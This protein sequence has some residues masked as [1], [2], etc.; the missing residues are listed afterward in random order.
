MKRNTFL[1]IFILIGMSLTPVIAQIA[2]PNSVTVN[3]ET[4]S[5][6]G[7]V[8]TKFASVGSDVEIMAHTRGHTSNT[9]VTADILRYDMDP[10][11]IING[12]LPLNGVIV[13][14]V[15]LQNTGYHIDDV[16]TMTW[17]GVYTVPVTSLGGTYAASIKAEHGN[18]IAVDDATQITELLLNKFET[19]VLQPLDNAWDTA[20]PLGEIKNEFA[21]LETAGTSN[22]GWANFVETATEGTGPG[23]SAQLWNNMLDAGR[24]QYDMEAGA[25]FLEALMEFLDS[26]DVDAGLDMVAAFLLYGDEFPLPRVI[27]DFGDVID[28]MQAFDPIE[29]FTR[30]EGTGDFE[31]AY[32]ALLGSNEWNDLQESIE[33]LANNQLP[34]QSI[35]NI[36]HNIALLAVS[37]HPEAIVDSLEAWAQ[38]LVDGDWESMTP[39]QKLIVRMAEMPEPIIEDYNGDDIPDDEGEITWQYELLLDTSEGQAWS[40]KMESSSS[41]VND[42]FDE[43]NSMPEHI[44]GHVFDSLTNPV[45]ESFG[46]SAEEFGEWIEDSSRSWHEESWYDWNS[47]DETIIFGECEYDEEEGE[48][49][50]SS[51]KMREVVTSIHDR[52]VLDIGITMEFYPSDW[53]QWEPYRDDVPDQFS[54]AM[55]NDKTPAD[56]ESTFL[57]RD[58]NEYRYYGRLTAST[59]EDTKWSFTQALSNFEPPCNDCEVSEA[60][61]EF[62]KLNPS[63]LESMAWENNDEMFIVS[64]V[65]VLVT[66]DETTN[67][68]DDYNIKATAYSHSG[69]IENAEVDLA[70]LR[71]SPQAAVGA[72]EA[73]EVEGEIEYEWAS[74]NSISGHYNADDLENGDLTVEINPRGHRD[75]EDVYLYDQLTFQDTFQEDGNGNSEWYVDISSANGDIGIAEVTTTGKTNSGIEFEFTEQIPMPGTPD[76]MYTEGY[77]LDGNNNIEL[78]LKTQSWEG[79]QYFD[80][81]NFENININWGDGTTETLELGSWESDSYDNYLYHQYTNDPG[82]ENQITVDYKDFDDNHYYHY[83]TYK[84]DDGFEKTYYDEETGED[85]TYYEYNDQ[86]FEWGM[87]NYCSLNSWESMTPSPVIIDSFITDGPFEVMKEE[88]MTSDSNGEAVMTVSPTLPG[89]YVSIAQVKVTR[90]DGSEM[91]GVGMN[92][93]A[94]TEGSISIGGDL[95]QETTFGGI[96]VYSSER[97]DLSTGISIA[98]TDIPCE[99]GH[100]ILVGLV[101]LVLREAFPGVDEDAWTGPQ[102]DEDGG[103]GSFETE[104]E[105]ECGETAKN[106]EVDLESPM[107]LLAAI[108]VDSTGNNGNN[109]EC[110]DV[111]EGEYFDD[112]GWFYPYDNNE[113]HWVEWDDYVWEDGSFCPGESVGTGDLILFPNAL[114]IG[115]VL[116][117]PASLKLTGELGPGQV[118]NIALSDEDGPASRILAVATPKEGFDPATIDLSA[119]TEFLYGEGVREEIGWVANDKSIEDVY[120][121]SDAWCEDREDYDWET[122]TQY[123]KSNVRMR[124]YVDNNPW[125]SSMPDPKDTVLKDSSGFLITPVRDWYQ[126]WGSE[127]YANYEIDLS[128]D[129]EL[130][131]GDH[132][133]NMYIEA[134]GED[135]NYI[136]NGY[137]SSEGSEVDTPEEIF[138]LIDSLLSNMGSI[139]WGQGSSADLELPI[140]SSPVGEYTIIAI[141]QKGEGENAEII[142]A[143][144]NMVVEATPN[145]EPP[146]I[147]DVFLSFSPP[148][149][150]VGD[151]VTIQVVDEDNIPVEGLSVT[152]K[153]DSWTIFSMVTSDAGQADF[154]V[155]E[156]TIEVL[157][158]GGNYNPA[159]ITIVVTSEGVTTED[160][161]TLPTEDNPLGSDNQTL[162][163]T[164]EDNNDENNND[165]DTGTGSGLSSALGEYQNIFIIIIAVLVVVILGLL[166]VMKLRG[167]DGDEWQ[168][169]GAAWDDYQDIVNAPV[170]YDSV[171]AAAPPSD[172]RPPNYMEGQMRDGYEV[173]EYPSGSGAWW[174]KDGRT[175]QW[176]EWK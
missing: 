73:F 23:G 164:N 70:V 139:A 160:G 131:L 8:T 140:L 66:Q 38:P 47:E 41:W 84:N 6:D 53:G 100:R 63:L 34:F 115:I 136:E 68:N 7:F 16:N 59:I 32:N 57:E 141:A 42:A 130:I 116:N 133:N 17:K 62:Q 125:S 61:I 55:T 102:N 77:M 87:Y 49:D 118:T 64:A 31:A 151:T 46:E 94:V 43:F 13:D 170:S 3:G 123:G 33:N 60:R 152:G 117:N 103:D 146:E 40:A 110:Y 153:R 76:C 174:Y 35:Q 148:N 96:P 21:S 137:H 90:A 163:N 29:N 18:M 109:D 75:G 67:V 167:R 169:D 155:Q 78:Y 120:I 134:V 156:G 37:I 9:Q 119:V 135:C 159:A 72:V 128:G 25:N 165:E 12:Q 104:L 172:G 69:P 52:N 50:C 4:L 48:E 108:A 44:L 83:F 147:K 81:T 56:V 143:I 20:N 121:S 97:G 24:D 1:M 39:L 15:V 154:I 11:Q 168:D 36:M 158:S 45:W 157:V 175:G 101:P 92:L 144:N 114:H 89:A 27:E 111:Q 82:Y 113:E 149:P 80:T 65:G 91:I 51:R 105:F 150:Q 26:E 98:P 10:I 85:V 161:E 129:Y 173:L 112:D 142:S 58:G 132:V 14:T 5:V 124:V 71:V 79:N 126:D 22:G 86:S 93:A 99:N 122:D 176:M 88:I 19:K 54:I 145:P 30:F 162:D 2:T 127:W 107:Y 28:H 138:D 106:W 171:P 166:T 74:S 95:N